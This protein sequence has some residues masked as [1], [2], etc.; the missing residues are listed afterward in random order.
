VRMENCT[1]V[2]Q[3]SGIKTK[4]KKRALVQGILQ[5]G[6]KYIGGSVSTNP[7][8]HAVKTTR[9]WVVTPGYVL[10]SVKNGSWLPEGPYE[11]TISTGSTAAFYPARQW[12]EKVSSGR[13]K[14]AFQGWR[15][16]L[17]V[18][19]PTRRAMFKRLQNCPPSYYWS[20][21]LFGIWKACSDIFI[22][23]SVVGLNCN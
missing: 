17:M 16:L 2:F 3:I 21:N 19:E 4:D 10:D 15:V 7:L 8:K 9:K 14:G 6:G 20:N 22:W 12:R 1:H 5:L 11:V 23:L 18:Q 13:L